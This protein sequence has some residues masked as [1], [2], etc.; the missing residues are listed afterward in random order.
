MSPRSVALED[1]AGKVSVISLRAFDVIPGICPAFGG[2]PSAL[3]TTS[4]AFKTFRIP[5]A[6]FSADGRDIDLSRVV[7]LSFLLGAPES[8]TGRIAIDD[9]EL[10][11]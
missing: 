4:A 1:A 8:P 3:E 2:P 11:P 5:I 10:S 7:K 6:G 9:V